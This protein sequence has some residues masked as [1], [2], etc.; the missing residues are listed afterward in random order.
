MYITLKDLLRI[1][2]EQGGTENDY[3]AIR[4]WGETERHMPVAVTKWEDTI[5]IAIDK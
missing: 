2:K 5:L 4:Y 1:I 3:V